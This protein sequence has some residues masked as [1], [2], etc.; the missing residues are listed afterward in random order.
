[1]EVVRHH[2]QWFSR[3]STPKLPLDLIEDVLEPE[4]LII[5]PV[6]TKT[7]LVEQPILRYLW[8][9]AYAVLASAQHVVFIGYSMPV[10][11]ISTG[12]LF[13]EGLRHM[14]HAEQITVVDYAKN[15]EERMERLVSL[16]MSYAKV[17]PRFSEAQ[18]AL[19]GG[20][21][22]IF[23]NLTRWLYDSMGN[24]IAFLYGK[25][26]ISRQGKFIGSMV[27]SMIVWGEGEG[28]GDHAQYK[29]E[30]EDDRL[31]FREELR[32]APKY[33]TIK[34]P[35]LPRVPSQ[36]PGPKAAISLR[37]ELRD[38]ALE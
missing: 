36:I 27:D 28:E 32:T 25:H 37:Q 1:L 30:V 20:R 21:A 38:L 34:Q 15:A 11:D 3:Y 5:P 22:W 35:A 16:H 19:C 14:N 6:L 7:A 17:F 18:I 23:D 9:R 13:R 8:A 29:G 10:T 26:V 2:E 12:Y 24:P 33:I 31:V 4:P